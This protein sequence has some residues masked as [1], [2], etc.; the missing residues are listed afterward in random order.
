MPEKVNF[1]RKDLFWDWHFLPLRILWGKS[2]PIGAIP[3]GYFMQVFVVPSAEAWCI[4]LSLCSTLNDALKLS[5]SICPRLY[6]AV[7]PRCVTCLSVLW[8]QAL[9][10]SLSHHSPPWALLI[11]VSYHHCLVWFSCLLPVNLDNRSTSF[12]AKHTFVYT[13]ALPLM[14]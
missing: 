2:E 4:Q 5:S 7:C 13:S 14:N 11:C 6:P 3:K 1:K 8:W 10:P 9:L 12:C